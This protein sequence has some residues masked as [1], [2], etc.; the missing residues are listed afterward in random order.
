MGLSEASG[1]HTAAVALSFDKDIALEFV[2][3]SFF[4]TPLIEGVLDVEEG[5]LLLED[6]VSVRVADETVALSSLALGP[7]EDRSSFFFDF[8]FGE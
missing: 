4:E 6:A 5:V 1:R 7:L 3:K 8:L 2:R